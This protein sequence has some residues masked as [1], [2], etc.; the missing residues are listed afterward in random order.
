[1]TATSRWSRRSWWYLIASV[2]TV[3]TSPAVEPLPTPRQDRNAA[4]ARAPLPTFFISDGKH[5]VVRSPSFGA[6]FDESK[7]LFFQGGR[8]VTLTFPGGAETVRPQAASPATGRAN[9]LLGS[10]PAHWRRD[11]PIVPAVVYPGLYPGIDLHFLAG[12]GGANSA[13]IKSEFRVAAG[14]DPG[15][16]ALSYSGAKS[17]EIGPGGELR[18]ITRAGEL[19]EEAPVVYQSIGGRRMDVT[20][21]FR[22]G[23]DGTVTFELGSYDRGYELVI[24]PVMTYSSYLGGSRIDSATAVAADSAGNAY[25]AGWA[26]SSDLALVSPISSLRGSVDA[27]VCKI[28]PSGTAVIYAT[29]LGGSGEDR[30]QAI[31]VDSLGNAWVAGYTASSNFPTASPLQPSRAGGR[32]AFVTRINAAGNAIIMSTYWGGGANDEANAIAIDQFNQ[33]YIAGETTSSN[34]PTRFPYQTSNRG[35]RDGFLFKIGISGQIS[36]STY[37]GGSGDDVVNAVAISSALTPYVSGCTASTNFPTR[38]PQQPALAGGQDAFVVRFDG[39]AANLIFGTY[40]GG[41]GGGLG[42]TE[43]ANA[44]AVDAFGNAYVAGVTSSTNFPLLN[45]F[46][47][48]RGG[49]TYDG[50]VTKVNSDGLRLYSSYLG[51]RGLDAATSIRVDSSR[52][53][54]VAGYTSSNNFPVVSSLQA[55]IGG[56]YDAFLVQVT[57]VGNTLSFGTYLGGS[58]SDTAAGLAYNGT[59]AFLVGLTASFDFP[60]KVPFQPAIAGGIDGWVTRIAF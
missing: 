23:S 33:A 14:A 38:N 25:V 47:P 8:C 31:E 48:V 27:F 53:A 41:N 50:F 59:S 34:F 36:F 2:V 19:R 5:F 26:E 3:V 44:M 37:L 39:D 24:D 40:L 55:N 45:A 6:Q 49:S 12:S 21:R 29:Y 35:A 9:L 20:G 43:C 42:R 30:A 57:T 32:D 4:F 28:N 54:Y 46:Q 15:R 18:V 11:L 52:R 16:I 22:V 10:D 13:V 58:S 51:G 56:A 7:I 1:M 60:T 17:V